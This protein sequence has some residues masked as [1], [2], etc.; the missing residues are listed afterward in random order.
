MHPLRPSASF[1]TPNQLFSQIVFSKL[2]AYACVASGPKILIADDAKY[3][4]VTISKH[5]FDGVETLQPVGHE[6]S[7]WVMSYSHQLQCHHF[8]VFIQLRLN[9]QCTRSTTNATDA[10]AATDAAT[11]S[12][13]TSHH[14][15]EAVHLQASV[16]AGWMPFITHNQQCQSTAVNK[17]TTE[18]C[19]N[20]IFNNELPT[21]YVWSSWLT[22]T[23]HQLPDIAVDGHYGDQHGKAKHRRSQLSDEKTRQSRDNCCCIHRLLVQPVRWAIQYS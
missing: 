18:H 3:L 19:Q 2:Y 13:A 9:T 5:S 17:K 22:A 23:S 7:E 11:T 8:S 21:E 15:A 20:K 12:K 10:D 16:F 4:E 14:H 6:R 1:L